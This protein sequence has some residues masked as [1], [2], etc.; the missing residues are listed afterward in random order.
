MLALIDGDIVLYRTAWVSEDVPEAI[1]CSR[2]NTTIEDILE[3]TGATEYQVWLSDSLENNYR[4][5]IDPKYKISRQSLPKPKHYHSLKLFLKY[6]WNAQITEGQ[7]ADDELGIRQTGCSSSTG[8]SGGNEHQQHIQSVICSIDKDLTQVP[9]LHYN[10]V[11]RRQFYV[12]PEQGIRQF[13]SQ[14][15]IGD[16]VDDIEGVYGIG[17]KRTEAIF[18]ECKT[19]W[20]LFQRVREKYNNDERLLKNGRLLWIRR[21]RNQMWTFPPSRGM[22]NL[23][24][25]PTFTTNDESTSGTEELQ[26]E[27]RDSSDL[28]HGHGAG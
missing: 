25:G 8:G 15:L 22:K 2:A 18:R 20:E 19:E 14:F 10:F 11:Q 24:T 6:E 13:Y 9:G 12:E 3:A 17:P 28:I 21:E 23:E 1:A 4:Y 27:A 16:R 7:E 5:K 26:D